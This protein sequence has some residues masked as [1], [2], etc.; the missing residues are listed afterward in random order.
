M[1]QSVCRP[2][3][4]VRATVRSV[5]GT[6]KPVELFSVEAD[7]PGGPNAA[8]RARRLV[9]SELLDRLP[10]RMVDDVALLLT[11][12][13]ANGVRHGGAGSDSSLHVVLEGRR[14]GLH[15]E[16]ANPDH[17]GGAPALRAADL[18]GGGGLGLNL[19]ETLASRWGVVRE[20]HTTVWFELDC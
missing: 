16:V 4:H 8:A 12:L 3:L 15:V 19:V 1:A 9:E 10:R 7:L 2:Q 5:T 13:V 18:G 6:L 14:P 11:E 17:V 20:P